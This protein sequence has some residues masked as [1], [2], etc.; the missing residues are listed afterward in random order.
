MWI[1]FCHVCAGTAAGFTLGV[2]LKWGRDSV[3]KK[4]EEQTNQLLELRQEQ[5][6]TMQD[7]STTLTAI[8]NEFRKR[9]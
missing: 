1:W 3:E 2:F 6:E 8:W 7:I 4:S 5:A 9:S